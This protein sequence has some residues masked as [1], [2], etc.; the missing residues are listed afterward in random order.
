MPS[1][2]VTDSIEDHAHQRR[3]IGHALSDRALREQ[4]YIL[5]NYTD[6]L[7]RR[8]NEQVKE[9]QDGKTTTTDMS[10]WYT[11][12]TFDTIGDLEFGES[13]HSLD[14]RVEHP[15]VSSILNGLKYG[16]IFTAFHHFPPLKAEWLTPSSMKEKA[17]E[18]SMWAYNRI[19]KRLQQKTDR[20]DFMHYVLENKDGEKGMSREEIDSN[21]TLLILAGSDT[22]ATTCTSVTWFLVKNPSALQKLQQ[23][24]RTSFK[25]FDD[26]T[27][28]TTAKLPYLHAVI[29]EALR[30]HPTAPISIPRQ[31]D[32][33]NVTISGHPV[34]VGVCIPL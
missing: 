7:I 14:N 15:W 21:A 2:A 27:V 19:E 16:M 10:N 18:H 13:F 6:H 26:I 24:V 23:E 11:Y 31:V 1:L 4:E 9:S 29:L 3:I 17:I 25:S 12:T 20:P 30:L 22:S 34:P 28:A 5:Q 8:L 32:R 33:P